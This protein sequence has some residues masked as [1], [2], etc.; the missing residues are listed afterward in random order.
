MPTSN[1]HFCYRSTIQLLSTLQFV[2]P[3]STSDAYLADLLGQTKAL[4]KLPIAV[5]MQEAATGFRRLKAHKQLPS[6]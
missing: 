2:V 4:S 3:R 1:N 5:A 6:P